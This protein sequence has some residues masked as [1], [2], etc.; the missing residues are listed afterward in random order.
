VEEPALKDEVERFKK[1]LN[2]FLL[3]SSAALGPMNVVHALQ[4]N[5]VVRRSTGTAS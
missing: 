3:G 5:E 4:H 1:A 2:R